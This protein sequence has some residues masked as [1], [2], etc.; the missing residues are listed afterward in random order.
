[1]KPRVFLPAVA[2]GVLMWAAFF[3]LDL[4]PVAFVA[5]APFLALA[6]APVSAKRRYLAAYVGGLA[7]FAPALQWLRVAHPMMYLSWVGLALTCP[8]AWVIGLALVRRLDRVPGVSLAAAAA[9]AWAGLEY[10]RAHAPTGFDFLPDRVHQKAGFGWYFLGYTQHAFLP[11]VQ[12]ADLGGVYAVSAVVAAVNG[13]AAE[14][15]TRTPAVRRWLRWGDA[16]A[17]KPW[18]VTGA[19]AAVVAGAVGYGFVRLAHPDFTPGPLIAALQGSV[20][21]WVK[22]GTGDELGKTYADLHLA[23][24]RA[25]PLPDLILWPETC[26]PGEWYDAAPGSAPPAD[27]QARVARVAEAFRRLGWVAPTL[28][29]IGATEWDAGRQWRYNSALLLTADGRPVGRYDKIHLVP[30]GEYVPF[31]ETFP[32]LQSFT[33]YEGDYSCRPG[34]RWTRFPVAAADGRRFTFGC[35]ICYEDSDPSLARRYVVPSAAGEPP[36]DFLVNV[37]N[38]GWFDGT[39]EHEQHLAICRFRAVESRR[40]VVRAVNMGVSAVIDADGRVVALPGPTWAGS[41]KMEGVM[42]AVV[43]IDGRESVYAR[44]GDVFAGACWVL[45][46]VGV[47]AG[48]F[49]VRPGGE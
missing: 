4:G 30:F 42:T 33:P 39:E 49:V 2:S 15:L 43:P 25:N 12:L 32:W 23:A 28:L 47:V 46:A 24:T 5:L 38:D 40:A 10:V 8:F 48:R 11:L 17:A 22:D 16:P 6:R 36:V 35:L 41:K 37:S 44:H 27:V 13:A 29:G 3:P 18:A 14:W 21:Q 1:M 7:F 26:F 19:T 34:S 20:P 9:V 31:R 45:V